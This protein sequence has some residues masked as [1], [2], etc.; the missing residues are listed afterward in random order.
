MRRLRIGLDLDGVLADWMLAFTTT[1]AALFPR[2]PGL[3]F[4]F[5]EMQRYGLE[6]GERGITTEMV[7]A[8]WATMENTPLWLVEAIPLL[9]PWEDLLLLSQIADAH[10]VH[11]VTSRQHPARPS[12]IAQTTQWLHAHGLDNMGLVHTGRKDLAAK[13]LE[14]DFYL[15]DDP[16]FIT[17][18]LTE[19]PPDCRVFLLDRAYNRTADT[20]PVERVRSLREFLEIV[21]KEAAC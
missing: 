15:D 3:P 12:V 13:A 1:M 17:Q 11:I 2:H 7:D 6:T 16:R 4:G 19:G 5:T 8:T 18:V 14:L 9:A 10:A 20:P 21:R